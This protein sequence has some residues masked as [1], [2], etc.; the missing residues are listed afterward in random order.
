MEQAIDDRD[1]LL[2]EQGYSTYVNGYLNFLDLV[3]K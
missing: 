3:N 2:F 1:L